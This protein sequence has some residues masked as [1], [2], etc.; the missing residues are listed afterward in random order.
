M[1]TILGIDAAWTATHPSGVALVQRQASQWRCIAVLPSYTAFLNLA[2][3][4]APD[5]SRPAIGSTPSAAR[6]LS[7]A[8]KLAGEPVTL[9]T[10]DMPVATIPIVGRRVADQE[11]SRDFGDQGCSAHSPGRSRPG[12]LGAEMSRQFLAEG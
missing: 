1:T 10:V 12:A 11:L 4:R 8:A 3:G 2:E 6:L 7:A 5:W 9:V